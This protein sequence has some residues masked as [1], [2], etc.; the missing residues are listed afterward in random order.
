MSI[1][2]SFLALSPALPSE[3]LSYILTRQVYPTTLLICQPRATFL[4]SLLNSID[5]TTP[6]QQPPPTETLGHDEPP[7]PPTPAPTQQH[8]L[9][10]PA[11]H[12]IATARHI[13]LVY[14]PTVTHLRAYLAAFPPLPDP[15]KTPPSEQV[16]DKLG[17]KVPLLVV[18]GPV[19]L[20][21]DTSEWSAQGLGNSVAG[22][23]DAGWRCGRRVVVLEERQG[24]VGDEVEEEIGIEREG[25][26]EGE[27]EKWKRPCAVWE[28]RVP[29]LNGS[30]RRA[31]L[32][33]EDGAWSGRTVE[34]GRVFA[35]W[36]EFGRGDW[37]T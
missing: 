36:F 20:H 33:S 13:T 6:R 35:R 12:Q 2:A 29:I 18:Y 21:R 5:N 11:L 37:V 24:G 31:G 19:E 28:Q 1:K 26:G 23:V 8:P 7:E 10:I 22:L 3:L 30:V 17:R 15:D 9:L 32:E 25:E 4:T 14:I 34:I 27:D 16:F